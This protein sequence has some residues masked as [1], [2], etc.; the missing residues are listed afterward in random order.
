MDLH[1]RA[2][3]AGTGSDRPPA[4]VVTV[5]LNTRWADEHQRDRVRIFLKNRAGGSPARRPARAPPEADLDWVEAQGEALLNQ[6][7]MPEPAA[8]PSSRARRWGS[9]R[10]CR[11]G[12]R[13][14]TPS[15][16]PRPRCCARCWSSSEQAP[17]TLV[18]FIDTET[19]RLVPLTA[20]GAGEEV[21][22][23]VRRARPPQPGRLGAAGA[24]TVPAAHPGP[25]GPAFRGGGGEPDR[26]GGRPWLAVDRAGGRAPQRRGV[27]P[28]AAAAPR[29]VDRRD[30]G[31]RPARGHRAHRRSGGRVSS[32]RGGAA[33]GRGRRRRV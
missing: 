33:G 12:F 29:R 28:G 15:R 31:R 2:D 9:A 13:S 10:S 5:Y 6:T 22:L 16:W 21:A 11:A 3:R 30:R 23:A 8:S 14:R 32:A 25:P 18:V 20:A 26:A 27:P 17:T 4:P 1:A 19:A 7:T 24:V